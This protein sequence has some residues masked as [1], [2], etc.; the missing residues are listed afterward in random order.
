MMRRWLVAVGVLAVGLIGG[1][2]RAAD[3]ADGPTASAD[4]SADI[5]D[6]FAWMSAD[7]GKVYLVMDLVRNASATSKFS[8]SVQYVF[9]TTSRA[10][11][12]GTAAP[13]VD[14][15][16][17]FNTAQKIQCWAG[18]EAYLSGDAS[19][20]SGI[21]SADGKLKVFAGLRDDPFFFNLAGFKET[22]KTVANAASS[23]T[24]DPAG[25]PQLDAP[26]AMALVTQLQ[27]APGGG[28]AVDNFAQFNVLAI[29]V[30]VDKSILTKGGPILGV[31]G[32]TYRL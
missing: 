31:W 23:L 14:V 5:T 15:I 7:A 21:V 25:C 22:G 11:F 9:H 17:T 6:V 27:T 2:V 32:G 26:T 24:F 30:A 8:D 16:C 4:P 1:P 10:S 29:V 20:P 3:H 18:K 12:G 13:E 19:N 28:P